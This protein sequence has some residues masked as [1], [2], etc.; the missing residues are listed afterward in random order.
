MALHI[1]SD[2]L[3]QSQMDVTWGLFPVP[4]RFP[5]GRVCWHGLPQGTQ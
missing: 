5:A 2:G 3:E 4:S 1:L